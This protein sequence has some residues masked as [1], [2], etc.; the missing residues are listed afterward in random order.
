MDQYGGTILTL[1]LID[2]N[3]KE[4]EEKNLSV[5]CQGLAHQN[6]CMNP[7]ASNLQLW[8]SAL[9]R[10]AGRCGNAR[11]CDILVVA[12]LKNVSV[13]VAGWPKRREREK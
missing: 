13:V 4:P 12:V 10:S 3:T 9:E 2:L 5:T 8:V 11:V 1:L 6:Q 7:V